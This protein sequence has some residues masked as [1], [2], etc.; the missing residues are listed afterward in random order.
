[1]TKRF[2]DKTED[3]SPADLDI[4]PGTDVSSGADKKYTFATIATKVK[5]LIGNATVS[6]SG[7]MS[8]ADKTTLDGLG[9]PG[10]TNT[11]GDTGSGKTLIKTK[12]GVVLNMKRLLAGANITLNEN[13]DDVEIVAA[14]GSGETNTLGDTGAETTI[15]KA[16]VGSA[17]NVK[18]LK[19]GANI[20]LTP[21]ADAVEII[22]SAGSGETN[23]LADTGAE[24]TLVKAKVGS[25]LNMKQLKAGA[26]I[27][28]TPT[29][30]AVEIIGAAGGGH[31]Q[32]ADLDSSSA[33]LSPTADDFF[34]ITAVGS[35]TITKITPAAGGT[36]YTFR[37][38]AG[39]KFQKSVIA[40]TTG[41]IR[42]PGFDSV[43]TSVLDDVLTFTY[44][45]SNTEWVLT[46]FQSGVQF[47][48]LFRDQSPILEAHLT[49]LTRTIFQS[50]NT[51]ASN[52]SINLTTAGNHTEITGT[53]TITT[54]S[55]AGVTQG[56]VVSAKFTDVLVLT[57]GSTIELPGDTNITTA[58]GDIATF[59]FDT[60][61][62][63]TNY[64]RAATAIT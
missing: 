50:K 60:N 61:W 19:A 27:T 55:T 43:F 26:N 12:V 34:Y 41:I 44:N 2:T 54:I 32:G 17:L 6:V 40:S 23:T 1:M 47:V 28:L 64:Q 37:C 56:T 51:I 33:E 20:T 30:D 16:K 35:Q 39:V 45:S 9:S 58:A 5:T 53:T 59:V 14:A 36:K 63:L 38:T 18:Q 10:E 25:V 31:S 11:L 4:L 24:T 3:T 42:F 8:A 46:G 57:H 29:G 21:T 48:E 22:A 62:L 13:A 52:A 15:V 7:L 49:T